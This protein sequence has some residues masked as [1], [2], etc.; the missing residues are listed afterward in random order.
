MEL[1]LAHRRLRRAKVGSA[2]LSM[3][4]VARRLVEATK[5]EKELAALAWER[6]PSQREATALSGGCR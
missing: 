4:T 1:T 2:G 6:A 3:T 5:S